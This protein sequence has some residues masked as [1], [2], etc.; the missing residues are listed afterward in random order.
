[1]SCWAGVYLTTMWM[2]SLLVARM[3]GH[4][5]ITIFSA[6]VGWRSGSIDAWVPQVQGEVFTVWQIHR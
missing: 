5:H 3:V 4:V 1:M 6:L 2:P